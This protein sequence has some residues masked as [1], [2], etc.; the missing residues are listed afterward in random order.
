MK[1]AFA[2]GGTG[3]HINPA[4]AIA[5]KLKNVLPDTEILF[6][7]SPSGLEAKLAQRRAMPFL[8]L[9]WREYS[10]DLPLKA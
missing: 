8:P 7:G 10:A 6:I 2:A 5:D 1:V 9:K 4:L 3:G